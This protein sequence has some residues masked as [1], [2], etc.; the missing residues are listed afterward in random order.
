M[1]AAAFLVPQWTCDDLLQL[2]PS[3]QAYLDRFL[4]LFPHRDQGA[5]FVAYAE[6]LLSKEPS[7]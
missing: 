1:A 3:L 7:R 5:S 2:K 4:P 6:E